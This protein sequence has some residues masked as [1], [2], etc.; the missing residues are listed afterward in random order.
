M[1]LKRL[2]H[3]CV[4]IMICAIAGLRD[5]GTGSWHDAKVI[6]SA[7]CYIFRLT[8]LLQPEVP[9]TS[10]LH[11]ERS[12][13]A[14]TRI[15]NCSASLTIEPSPKSN[16][17][18]CKQSIAAATAVKSQPMPNYCLSH[19]CTACT[20]DNGLRATMQNM[21]AALSHAKHLHPQCSSKTCEHD[22]PAKAHH[23]ASTQVNVQL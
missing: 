12:L 17:F 19:H 4:V 9:S 20:A 23:T 6:K 3:A 7:T 1:P 15:V 2:Q 21:A 8:L 10:C 13:F 16:P 5:W 11:D 18:P 14:P 22:S